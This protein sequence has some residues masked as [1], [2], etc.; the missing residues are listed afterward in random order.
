MNK[1]CS[2]DHQ[3]KCNKNCPITKLLKKIFCKNSQASVAY[4]TLSGIIGKGSKID[5]GLN[6]ETAEGLLK[7]AFETKNIKAVAIN[8]N[9]PGGS[10]VQSELIFQRIRELS[11]EKKIPVYTFAQDLAASGGYFILSAGDEVYAHDASI[12][13]SIGVVSASFGF[14]EA[15]KKIG[16]NRRVYHEGKN[17]AMLDPFMPESAEGVA[18]LKQLQQDVFVSFKAIVRSR[19][20]DKL[21]LPEDELF[22]GS[23][24]SGSRAVELGLIDKVGNMRQVMKEKFGDKVKLIAIE[25][26]KK[27]MIKE[28][29]ASSFDNIGND[30]A[31]GVVNKIEEKIEFGKFKI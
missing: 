24:W 14:E 30:L 28:L 17:K 23:F 15:I 18:M 10:P 21:K 8:V 27:G 7:R 25:P 11:Q 16:V 6:I 22:D 26:K 3:N 1:N 5:G 29:L 13:G 20:G 31:S 4:L 2:S 19:R 12:V 9:S